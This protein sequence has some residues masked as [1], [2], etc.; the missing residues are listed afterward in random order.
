MPSGPG[1][2]PESLISE[3]AASVP[4]PVATFLLTSEI[5]PKKIIE[6]QRRCGT[7]TLQLCDHLPCSV[8]DQ[9][10]EELPGIKLVQ[11]VHVENEESVKYAISAADHV[12]ALL[13]DSGN[14]SGSVK[15]FGGTGRTHDWNL[16]RQIR[17]NIPIPVFLAG[18]L[19][20]AN[21]ARAIEAV[22]PFGIDLCSSVRTNNLLDIEKLETFFKAIPNQ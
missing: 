4:P 15:E 21:V 12:D 3:I 1:M 11:V 9:I 6:Q 10:R 14:L 18:G 16:S 8:H 2:I 20:S 22:E 19:N 13:L 17:D 7:N 5:Q